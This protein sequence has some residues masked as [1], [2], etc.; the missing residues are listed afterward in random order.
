VLGRHFTFFGSAG[1]R[2]E[3]VGVVKDAKY[4]SLREPVPPTFYLFCFGEPKDWDMT[5]AIRTVGQ[6][7]GIIESLRRAVHQ[8]DPALELRGVRSMEEVVNHSLR[9]ERIVANLGGYFSLTALALACLGI[10]GTLSFSVAQ[11]VR[12]IGVRVALGAPRN[13][14]LWLVIAKGLKL[15]L[16]GSAIGLAGALAVTRLVS[17]LLYGVSPTDPLT[18]ASVPVAFLLVGILASLI[19]ARRATRVDPVTALRAD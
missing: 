19:P 3:I 2:F 12:E 7:T 5:L 4:G 6:P 8:T 11:R 14:V 9:R 10:Y 16:T 15:A 1:R 18:F 13:T 17:R